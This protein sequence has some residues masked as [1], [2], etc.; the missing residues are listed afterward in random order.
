MDTNGDPVRTIDLANGE[1]CWGRRPFA[2]EGKPA[3]DLFWPT[4][5][6]SAVK[7]PEADKS[8][9]RY[10][11][12]PFD[13]GIHRIL[14]SEV[15]PF[16][17][18]YE[19][20]GYKRVKE[21]QDQPW[22]TLFIKGL[23]EAITELGLKS[24]GQTR[25][26]AQEIT[27]TTKPAAT[28]TRKKRPKE[29]PKRKPTVRRDPEWDG[30]D[31]TPIDD[32]LI[33]A[34]SEFEPPKD[35]N[36]IAPE[37]ADAVT[38]ERPFPLRPSTEHTLPLTLAKLPSIER[39][40]GTIVAYPVERPSGDGGVVVS[41]LYEYFRT[42]DGPRLRFGVVADLN[43]PHGKFLVCQINN[44][45]KL[46]SSMREAAVNKPW[47]D[48]DDEHDDSV[49]VDIKL[50]SLGAS[51]WIPIRSISFIADVASKTAQ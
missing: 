44:L 40:A 47:D 51:L 39:L 2:L 50:C 7:I 10:V 35:P 3:R 32:F 15:L 12:K 8:Q 5:F 11:V 17:P 27:M 1:V 36:S 25:K 48:N 21:G 46:V 4:T 34:R 24:F 37:S 13:L 45:E 43:R 6:Q 18:H 22:Y 16:F 49:Y 38:E 26:I 41:D 31:E 19:E 23:N 42:G 20:P 28:V 29:Q 30:C 9:S 33:L 14:V